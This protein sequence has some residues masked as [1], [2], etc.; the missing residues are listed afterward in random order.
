VVGL[1]E[2]LLGVVVAEEVSPFTY[3]HFKSLIHSFIHSL[4][5]TS[6]SFR[7]WRVRRPIWWYPM[8]A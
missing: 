7:S 4:E 6:F 2:Q 5:N 3:F 8:R 1:E